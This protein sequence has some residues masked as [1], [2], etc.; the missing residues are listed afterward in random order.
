MLLACGVDTPIHINRSHLLAL[1][2][3]APRVLCGLGLKDGNRADDGVRIHSGVHFVA[4]KKF[5][6]ISQ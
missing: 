3:F 1:H 2:C 5:Q 6:W 4:I